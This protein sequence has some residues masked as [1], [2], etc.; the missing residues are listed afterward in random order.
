MSTCDAAGGRG[1][2]D[3][4]QRV[5]RRRPR[6]AEPARSRRSRSRCAPRRRRPRP[7]TAAG[8]AIEPGSAVVTTGS[9]RCGAAVDGGRELGRELAEAARARCGV[10]QGDDGQV[11]EQRRAAVAEHHLIAVRQ[12]RTARPAR[13]APP[14]PAPRTGAWRCEVPSRSARSPARRLDRL[15]SH[16]GRA[17]AE[18]AV[19]RAADRWECGARSRPLI[20]P[21]G[22]DQT[23]VGQ[24]PSAAARLVSCQ[25][26]RAGRPR[27]RAR[28]LRG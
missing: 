23:E 19:G 5:R 25:T 26:N 11:P 3:D 4:H 18:P 7:A 1:A 28:R 8:S 13:T 6:S 17:G 14:R 22:T 2:V 20:L 10:D 15:R 16:L 24:H 12:R 21:L 27:R 9:S